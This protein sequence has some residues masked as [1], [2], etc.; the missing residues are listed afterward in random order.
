MAATSAIACTRSRVADTPTSI[1]IATGGPGGTFYPVAVDLAQFY[2]RNLPGITAQLEL[3]GS[4]ANVQ[5]VQ[6]GRAQ[7]AFAQA[8]IAYIAYRRGTDADPRPFS[9]L[10]GIAV[11]WPN[12]VQIAVPKDSA[13]RTVDDLRGHRVAVGTPGSGT[14]TLARIVLESYGLHY[15]DIVAV[16]IPFVEMVGQMRHHTVDAAFTVASVPSPVIQ[17]M[18]ADP[19]VRLIPVARERIDAVRSQY[20]F[21][22]PIVVAGGSYASEHQDVPTLGVEDILLCRDDL[23]EEMAY[24]LTKTFFDSLPELAK[25]HAAVRA[26]DLDQAPGTALPLHPGAARYYRERE[27]VQ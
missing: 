17:Q 27:I 11:L 21:L 8:D 10:R 12:T 24:K 1:T 25:T 9:R 22:R 15:T 7:L 3:G 20:P 4:G 14:E 13:I 19:G 18:N 16:F 23:T 5:A 2:S 26:I 6:D